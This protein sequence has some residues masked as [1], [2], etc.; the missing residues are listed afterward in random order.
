MEEDNENALVSFTS[1]KESEEDLFMETA[2]VYVIYLGEETV[3]LEQFN[4]NQI[5]FL[6]Q[7][8]PDMELVNASQITFGGIPANEMVYTGT[9]NGIFI[10]TKQIWGIDADNY[11]YIF[12]YAATP[13]SFDQYSR[14]VEEMVKSFTLYVPEIA[15]EPQEPENENGSLVTGEWRVYSEAIYYDTG[16]WNFLDTPVTTLLELKEDGTWNFGTSTGTYSIVEI[17]EEDWTKW[18]VEPYGPTRKLVLEGWNSSS[19]DGPIEETESR[20]D[21]MWVIYRAEPPVVE[22]SGQ[23]QMKFGHTSNDL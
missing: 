19:A 1:L 20:V 2:N 21:F 18:D 3:T 11:A 22:N 10:Q 23:I 12:T 7:Q 8:I 17:S 15:E 16:G 6:A 14:I 13:D 4:D 9:V 5:E